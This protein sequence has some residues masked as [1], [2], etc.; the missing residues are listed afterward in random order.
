MHSKVRHKILNKTIGGN[1]ENHTGKK[2]RR[3]QNCPEIFT[4]VIIEAQHL[5]PKS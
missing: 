1:L 2:C 5:D 4:K 3:R